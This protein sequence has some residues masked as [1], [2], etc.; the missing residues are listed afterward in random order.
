MIQTNSDMINI[1]NTAIMLYMKVINIVNPK[2]SC[3][4]KNFPLFFYIYMR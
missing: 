4:K 2:S 1:I 3:H